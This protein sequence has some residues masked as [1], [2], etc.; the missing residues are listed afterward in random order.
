MR[1]RTNIS[2]ILSELHVTIRHISA[3][4]GHPDR[5]ATAIYQNIPPS[6]CLSLRKQ[7][8]DISSQA[9]GSE[10]VG[11]KDDRTVRCVVLAWFSYVGEVYVVCVV[12]EGDCSKGSKV[13]DQ[14]IRPV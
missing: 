14:G 10:T 11:D 8:K 5:D 7:R 12:A 9:T 1:P 4:N 3:M 13:R 6:F 2:S